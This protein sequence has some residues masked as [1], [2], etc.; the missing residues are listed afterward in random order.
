MG[1]ASCFKKIDVVAPPHNPYK[2]P[3]GASGSDYPGPAATWPSPCGLGV[4]QVAPTAQ[5]G[6]DG[7]LSLVSIIY[8]RDPGDKEASSTDAI[9]SQGSELYGAKMSVKAVPWEEQDEDIAENFGFAGG[10]ARGKTFSDKDGLLEL[11]RRQREA[12]HN[13][14]RLPDL[15]RSASGAPVVLST[16]PESRVICQGLV[17]DCSFLSALSTLAEYERKFEQPVLSGILHPRADIGDGPRPVYNEY[18]KY[19]CRLFFNGTMRKVVIDDRVPV[20]HD[21]RLL[22]AHSACVRELWVTLLEKSFAKIM[23]G[24]YDMQGSNPGTDVFH[25]TGWVP[26]TIQLN[27]DATAAA[28]QPENPNMKWDEVFREAAEGYKA[29]RCVVCVGT[30]ELSDAAPDAEAKRLGHI[31]GVSISTG[32]VSRHAYPV[33]DCRQVGSFRMLRLKN[34]WGRVRWRGR[35]SPGDGAWREAGAAELKQ[36]LGPEDGQDKDDG[37]FWILW[38]DVVKYFSHLYLCWVPGKLGLALSEAHGRWDP[39]TH[40]Q[41]SLLRDDTHLVAFNP[42]LLL[43]FEKPP[44]EKGP[45]A[46]LLL[47]RHVRQRSELTSKYVA[48]HIYLGKERL[49]CPNAPLEQG[50]YSNGECALV[51]LRGEVLR[52]EQDLV[53]VVSQHAHKVAFNFTIQVYTS[54][55]A[56]LSHLPP[57]V[58]DDYC[59]GAGMGEWTQGTGGGCSNNL[60]QYF[61]NPQWRLEVPGEPGDQAVLFLFLECADEHSVN[62]RLFQGVAAKPEMVRRAESSGPYRQGCC[63]LRVN[64]IAPGPYVAVVSTFRPGL[65]GRYRL[66]WHSTVPVRLGPQPHPFVASPMPPLQSVTRRVQCSAASKL[67]VLATGQGPTLVSVR[68]QSSCK[69]GPLPSLGLFSTSA[70]GSTMEPVSC[71][72]LTSSF[73]ETYFAFSGA[74]V[75]LITTL[76]PGSPYVLQ[77]TTPK[78]RQWDEVLLSLAA[79]GPIAVNS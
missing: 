67:Q 79:D 16:T 52:G 68:L 74:A 20:R 8:P 13:W 23:G 61:Q 17:G 18:G 72:L 65:L 9:L 21:G 5:P 64:N 57:L 70:S 69:E 36:Q 19:G 55:P 54:L 44:P 40:L 50:V 32:L 71:E 73:A 46:W 48:V 56:T 31:E 45:A 75:L 60:W 12:L 38:E 15:V 63:M 62:I 76:A 42:Q 1:C 27:G 49:C 26:E 51:K 47:S 24:S 11:S 30:S 37:H 22:C 66:A 39:G 7:L 35:F 28:R 33:L 34:P 29:G 3:P 4:Q 10:K 53:L 6:K 41:R 78:E 59:S 2:V 43:H 58:P 25:L 14:R 77:M